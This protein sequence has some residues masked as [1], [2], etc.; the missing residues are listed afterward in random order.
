MLPQQATMHAEKETDR[1]KEDY[2]FVCF[3]SVVISKPRTFTMKRV[4]TDEL[5][6]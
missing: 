3:F 1:V 6:N 2:I 4:E 5:K